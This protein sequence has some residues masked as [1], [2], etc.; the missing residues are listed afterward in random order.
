MEQTEELELAKE[1]ANYA[2]RSTRCAYTQRAQQDRRWCARVVLGQQGLGREKAARRENVGVRQVSKE[3]AFD[4]VA[5]HA[6]SVPPSQHNRGYK[7]ACSASAR[8]AAAQVKK[9]ASQFPRI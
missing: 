7:A 5:G 3:G 9:R 4:G 2:P 8:A 6:R 1:M